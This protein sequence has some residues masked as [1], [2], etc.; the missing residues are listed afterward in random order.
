MVLF[1]EKHTYFAR[2]Q[3]T[4]LGRSGKIK[5]DLMLEQLAGILNSLRPKKYPQEWHKVSYDSS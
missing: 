4:K 2:G 1:M 5:F 3:K